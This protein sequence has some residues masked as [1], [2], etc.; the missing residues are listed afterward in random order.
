MPNNRILL[1]LGSRGELKFP[2]QIVEKYKLKQGMKVYLDILTP[3]IA[4]L[5]REDAIAL[6][7]KNTD[8]SISFIGNIA[9]FGVADI[10]SI[11]NMGQKTGA[12]IF[13]VRD[14]KK[15]VYFKSGEIVFAQS[16]DPEDR[17]GNILFKVGKITREQL[18]EAEKGMVAG[19]RFGT[20]LLEKGY[21]TEKDLWAGIKYQIEEIVYSVFTLQEGMYYF[22]EGELVY[23]DLGRF[24]LNTQNILMEGYRRLD[25]MTLIKEKIPSKNVVIRKVKEQ[26]KAPLPQGLQKL[27]ELIDGKRNLAE[28]IRLSGMGEFNAFKAV[29]ELLRSDLIEVV[30]DTGEMENDPLMQIAAEYVELIKEIIRVVKKYNPKADIVK[31]FNSFLQ[32]SPEKLRPLYKGVTFRPNGKLDLVAYLRNIRASISKDNFLTQISG[33]EDLLLKQRLAEGLNEIINFGLILVK[34]YLPRDKA[35]AVI[36]KIRSMQKRIQ[37]KL[38]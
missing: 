21:I 11:I 29:Y 14:F 12:L 30:E 24:S 38:E 17:L 27:W 9:A 25:E 5:E 34:K 36:V 13:E 8:F 10:F 1:E 28:L 7:L 35:D 33:M 16:T 31:L 4:L 20:I 3:S 2:A 15:S 26:P 23:R 18:K 22:I 6:P 37:K 32:K 19:K